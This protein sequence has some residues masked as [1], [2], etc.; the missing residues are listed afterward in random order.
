MT[1][2][3][4]Y[5]IKSYPRSSLWIIPFVAVPLHQVAWALV[6]TLDAQLAWKGLA[7]GVTDAQAMFNAIDGHCLTRF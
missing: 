3:R 5:Q 4:R 6:D 7:L 1:W 2:N